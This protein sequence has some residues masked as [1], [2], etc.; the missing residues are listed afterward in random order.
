MSARKKQAQPR[1]AAKRQ[2]RS[3][4]AT[5]APNVPKITTKVIQKA[6]WARRNNLARVTPLVGGMI[7][8][9]KKSK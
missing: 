8:A 6:P 9:P 4:P 1:Q 3:I 7:A 2:T 5:N